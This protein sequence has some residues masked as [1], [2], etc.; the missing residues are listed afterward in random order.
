M[1]GTMKYKYKKL[2]DTVTDEE[3]KSA[4]TFNAY[5]IQFA[6]DVAIGD[7]GMRGNEVIEILEHERQQALKNETI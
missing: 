1:K 3:W 6:V 2:N 4:P 7:D 5:Q